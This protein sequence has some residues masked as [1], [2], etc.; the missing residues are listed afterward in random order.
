M[1][2]NV[3]AL[4]LDFMLKERNNRQNI[5][6]HRE[7]PG[8]EDMVYRILC[9]GNKIESVIGKD[10]SI[11]KSLRHDTDAKIKVAHGMSGVD[12]RVIIIFRSPKER[13]MDRDNEDDYVV[14]VDGNHSLCAAQDALFRVLAIIVKEGGGSDDENEDVGNQVHVR[15]LVPNN[16]IGFLHGIG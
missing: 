3:N 9:P 10:D 14:L 7:M 15:L 1:V 16:Q 8:I 2:T 11:I 4:F 6:G 12:K 5:G 13:K